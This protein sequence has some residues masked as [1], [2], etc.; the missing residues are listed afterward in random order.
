MS[1]TTLR[2][3]GRIGNSKGFAGVVLFFA[4]IFLITE[5]PKL[6]VALKAS[7]EPQSVSI[8]QL[9][10]G[11]VD[12]DQYVTTSGIAFYDASY[13]RTRDD[14]TVAT[15]YWLLDDDTGH[16][17]VVKASTA[18]ITV[19]EPENVT[20]TGMTHS[21]ASEL[22]DLIRSDMPD[23]EEAGFATTSDLFLGK[24]QTPPNA[25][26]KMT[27]VLVLSVISVVCIAS[28]F[29]PSAVFAPR[30]VDL[31]LASLQTTGHKPGV[32][33]TGRFLQIK[34]LEPAVE[35]G[36][37][38]RKFNNAVANI[39]PLEQGN[40]LIHI[41]HIMRTKLSGVV[42]I[43]T[44]KSDWG[45]F[46]SGDQVID[47]EPGKLYGWGDRWAV[48]LRY[49]GQKDKPEAMFVSFDHA[50]FQASFVELLQSIGFIDT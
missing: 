19:R 3:R 48:R 42:T 15:Y 11:E 31:E 45:I 37:S 13:E 41:H 39:V 12:A 32:Q 28:F 34:R 33:A 22:R 8:E 43:R 21:T 17:I 25:I 4:I 26:Q 20:L 23:I 5:A 27:L 47:I 1:E 29:F 7:D 35:F 9:V 10:N 50:A 46:I 44:Q 18:R 6:S 14:K 40:L 49:K 30:P 38:T 36:K 2:W 24:G 16:L